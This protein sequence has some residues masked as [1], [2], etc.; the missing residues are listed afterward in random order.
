[1]GDMGSRIRRMPNHTMYG[2]NP[3]GRVVRVPR[4]RKIDMDSDPIKKRVSVIMNSVA[5]YIRSFV[6]KRR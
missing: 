2:D 6:D 4:C 1:M 5:P 3:A